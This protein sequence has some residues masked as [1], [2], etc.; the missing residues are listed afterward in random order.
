MKK[1][2][3]LFK[4]L[5]LCLAI[6]LG[7]AAAGQADSVSV[8]EGTSLTDVSLFGSLDQHNQIIQAAYGNYGC[9]VTA[10]ANA[11]VYLQKAYPSIYGTSLVS[12]Y[13]GDTLAHTAVTLGG[14]DY[15]NV[16]VTRDGSN[17]ITGAGSCLRDQ[18]WGVYN[19]IEGNAAHRT[20]Y[21]AQMIPVPNYPA[22]P[23]GWTLARPQPTWVKKDFLYPTEAFLSNAL[24]N[25]QG[26]VICWNVANQD[27]MW[28]PG[29]SH[30]LTV[31]GLTW[32]SSAKSGT[33]YFIDPSTGTQRNS[34]FRQAANSVMLWL[35][36]GE[37]AP[38]SPWKNSN[39]ENWWYSGDVRI[40]LALAEGPAVPLPSTV[41]L[42][43]SG[44]LG[45]AGVGRK[46]RK[47]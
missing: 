30:L 45:L 14:A 44:L 5:S 33:L 35:D 32:D 9:Q 10:Y 11:L 37:Y 3:V 25:K 31:T 38:G 7:L 13:S 22:A 16:Y 24:R 39:G 8:Y 18:V 36:Y 41:L 27:G 29:A 40:T 20:V 23:G 43:G 19:Y 2:R 42:L 46:L 34:P 17:N 26:L 1:V 28:L 21:G 4:V 15:M 12:D 6:L 47:S